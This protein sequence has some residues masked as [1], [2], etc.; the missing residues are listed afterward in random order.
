MSPESSASLE[1][2]LAAFIPRQRVITDPLRL[3]T[4]G[5]DASFYRM[6][7]AVVVVVESEDEVVDACVA[8]DANA[9]G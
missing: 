2:S 9:H 8:A 6:I 7:R 3:L 5:T 4:W 1:R